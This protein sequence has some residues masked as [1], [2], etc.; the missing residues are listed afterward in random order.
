MTSPRAATPAC[1]LSTP[2]LAFAIID[3]EALSYARDNMTGLSERLINAVVV[4]SLIELTHALLRSMAYL[5]PRRVLVC[6]V[7]AVRTRRGPA[8][9]VF[10]NWAAD[11]PEQ[12]LFTGFSKFQSRVV[13]VVARR[14]GD[15]CSQLDGGF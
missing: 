1:S 4:C 12:P 7:G 6:V 14:A 11:Q 10:S 5:D 8:E 13:K 9:S 2:R 15:V 3:A